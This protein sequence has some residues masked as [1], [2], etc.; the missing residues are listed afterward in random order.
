M[1]NRIIV[2]TVLIF[3]FLAIS[4]AYPPRNTGRNNK[5]GGA[6]LYNFNTRGLGVDLRAEF[7]INRLD[8]LEGLSIVPQIS[9][10]PW[11]NSVSE[12]TAG[13][14]V[15]LGV[16]AID[17]WWFYTL[18]NVS[19]NGFI[20]HQDNDIREGDFSN[21]GIDAGAGVSCKL[22]KCLHPFFEFRYTIT[23]S[24][25]GARAGVMVDLNCNRRGAVPCSKIPP[26]PQ[27]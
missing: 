20:N 25:F 1:R 15:H 14:D 18:A 16:Y 5:A 12:F 17:R 9:Y 8:L 27:F 23:W 6:L 26:Q 24:D 4:Y 22:L 11:F 13:T 21:L 19:Y 2:S 10:Y 3:S 7:P